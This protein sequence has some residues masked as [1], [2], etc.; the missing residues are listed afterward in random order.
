MAGDVFEEQWRSV[1]QDPE[2][3]A[4]RLQPAGLVDPAVILAQHP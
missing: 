2:L 3:R 4:K 1:R